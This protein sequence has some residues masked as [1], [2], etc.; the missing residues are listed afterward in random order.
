MLDRAGTSMALENATAFWITGRLESSASHTVRGAW[1]C[2]RTE[3]GAYL[4]A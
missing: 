1:Q 4:Q 3:A 2:N